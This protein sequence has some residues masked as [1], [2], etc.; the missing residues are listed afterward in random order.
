MDFLLKQFKLGQVSS[1]CLHSLPAG[2]GA[3]HG[4][5]RLPAF[6]GLDESL[7]WSWNQSVSELRPWELV[8]PEPSTHGG[9]G[10]EVP[11]PFPAI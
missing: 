2:L 6:L 9:L 10:R 11:A 5:C 8:S 4:I 7:S 3:T 1:V